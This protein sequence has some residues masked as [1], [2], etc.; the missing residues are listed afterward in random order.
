MV[1]CLCHYSRLSRSCAGRLH[2]TFNG[3]IPHSFYTPSGF[4]VSSTSQKYLK[5][6]QGVS[7]VIEVNKGTGEVKEWVI[8]YLDMKRVPL[9][10]GFLHFSVLN[11]RK[12]SIYLLCPYVLISIG[13][14]VRRIMYGRQIVYTCVSEQVNSK[15]ISCLVKHTTQLPF[16]T[17]CVLCYGL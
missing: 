2:Y 12:S 11:E 15:S 6:S 8:Q 10:L 17:I 3:V 1:I 14:I 4:N 9:A 13:C 5:P 16:W 7:D